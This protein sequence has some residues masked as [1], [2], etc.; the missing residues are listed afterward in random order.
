MRKKA[1]IS[2]AAL[3][4]IACSDGAVSEAAQTLATPAQTAATT[5]PA[6]TYTNS[7]GMVF[8]AIPAGSFLMGSA[9]GDPHAFAVEKPQRRV[10]I[11]KPYYIG[12]YEVTQADWQTVMGE[13]PYARA[14]SNP[15]YRLPG[16]AARITK[17]DHPAT[18]SWQDAQAFITA[19]NQRENTRR[20][21]LPSEA[22]WEY[23]ARA[24]TQ[25]AY[26]FG[27]SAADLGQYA[28]FGE[29]FARG[30]THPV[31]QKRPNA[32]GLYDVHGNVWEWVEDTFAPYASKTP[33]G[34]QGG[35]AGR[36]K[37]VR[38]GS[39][40]QTATSWR[41][42]FRKGYPPDYRGISIGFRLVMDVE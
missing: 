41:S 14:R 33:Q 22:E 16:M 35:S 24:G 42:A 11:A 6:R 38:G 10:S 31:G 3:A 30:G 25:S 2:L 4:A 28:W 1:P 26:S 12:Q 9:D 32:W 8:V 29:D 5:A 36:D 7:I 13:N 39:W 37:T 34:V 23:A 17:P 19:L 15:Y 21:R 40:Y 20:Y 18:V 27:D